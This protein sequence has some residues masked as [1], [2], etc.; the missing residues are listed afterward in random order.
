MSLV[1][2]FLKAAGI[3][4]ELSSSRGCLCIMENPVP[5]IP[6]KL[7]DHCTVTNLPENVPFLATSVK[8]VETISSNSPVAII[9]GP[10]RGHSGVLKSAE[11]GKGKVELSICG[12]IIIQTINLRDMEESKVPWA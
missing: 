7:K 9:A 1:K 8:K 5:H 4:P 2:K 6:A 11:D 3:K 10:Y 12:R